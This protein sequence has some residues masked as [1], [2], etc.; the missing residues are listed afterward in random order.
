QQALIVTGQGF[1]QPGQRITQ[2]RDLLQQVTH[3]RHQGTAVTDR[4]V[5]DTTKQAVQS[6]VTAQRPPHHARQQIAQH[7]SLPRQGQIRLEAAITAGQTTTQSTQQL[8][9]QITQYR[10][11]IQSAGEHIQRVTF[12]ATQAT[13][14]Q[15]EQGPQEGVEYVTQHRNLTQQTGQTGQ[16]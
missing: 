9:Q 1:Q 7:R 8:V 15:A 11:L 16:L 5:E 6:Q 13:V 12:T 10:D 3:G 2:G 14:G 4:A